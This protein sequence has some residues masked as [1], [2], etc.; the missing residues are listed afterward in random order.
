MKRVRPVPPT[1]EG[2]DLETERRLNLG[3]TEVGDTL[4]MHYLGGWWQVEMIENPAL[5]DRPGGDAPPAAVEDG[6]AE[7]GEVVGKADRPS[8]GGRPPKEGSSKLAERPV[9]SAEC[10]GGAKFT[11]RALKFANLHEGV[12][13]DDLRPIWIWNRKGGGKGKKRASMGGEGG[14]GGDEAGAEK[15]EEEDGVEDEEEG[16]GGADGGDKG[17]PGDA[18]DAA[19]EAAGFAEGDMIEGKWGRSRGR[20]GKASM[21]K[22]SRYGSRSRLTYDLGEGYL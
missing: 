19:G 8:L 11:V 2:P 21:A 10:V 17:E 16:G 20:E 4:E 14:E 22:S 1:L 18:G 13:A 5:R 3:S 6:D 9:P 12:S 15:E 7:G